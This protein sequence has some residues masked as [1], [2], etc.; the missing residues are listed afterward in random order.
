[1]NEISNTKSVK[2]DDKKDKVKTAISTKVEK[3]N[4]LNY[5]LSKKKGCSFYD[6][7]T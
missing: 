1:M 3:E 5:I 6:I 2:V 7:H 4:V